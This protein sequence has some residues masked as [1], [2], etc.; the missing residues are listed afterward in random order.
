MKSVTVSRNWLWIAVIALLFASCKPSDEKIAEAVKAKIGAVASTVNVSVADGVA[1][2]TGEV[3]DE[4]T[5]AAA[6]TALQGIKGL[7][8]V[9]NSLTIPP[10]P[11]PPVVINPD[12]VLRKGIDSVF[13]A[14]SIKGV[15]A[16]VAEGV[17][18]LTGTIKKSELTKVMQAANEL[19]PKKVLNQMTIK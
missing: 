13:A 15:S 7:K 5:K 10:P 9:V 1:T 14:K 4:A 17:L 18:T 11:P 16:A 12:D 19:K 6:E 8:S 3:N 2:L